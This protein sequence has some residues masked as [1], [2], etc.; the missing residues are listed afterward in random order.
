[1]AKLQSDEV[2]ELGLRG[3]FFWS[4]GQGGRVQRFVSSQQRM[5]FVSIGC[6]LCACFVYWGRWDFLTARSV[7]TPGFAV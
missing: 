6:F 2:Q 3:P 7:P 5:R 1:M 4:G